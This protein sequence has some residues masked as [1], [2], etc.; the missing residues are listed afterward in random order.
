MGS[1]WLGRTCSPSSPRA[2]YTV[3]S[4]GLVGESGGVHG[5]VGALCHGV[6][7]VA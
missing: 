4:R 5:G 1:V 2:S 3:A 6:V 7:L